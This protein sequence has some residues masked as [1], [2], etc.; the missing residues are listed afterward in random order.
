[1]E[2]YKRYLKIH[3]F[4]IAGDSGYP[5]RPYFLT[6]LANPR[7]R[8]EQLYNEAHIRT[9]NMVERVIGIWKRRF[10]VMAYGMRL[11]LD[12]VLTVIV[13]TAVLHNI[14]REMN[15]PEPPLPE[16]INIGELNYLI[17]IGQMPNIP[18]LEGDIAQDVLQNG[19][20]LNYFSN[21]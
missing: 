7:T 4:K 10:P 11:K 13:A 2:V 17:E 19:V 5:L 6:P 14:A 3:F 9:R 15:E 18:A 20:V 1:M 8:G 21:L 12:T 16:D